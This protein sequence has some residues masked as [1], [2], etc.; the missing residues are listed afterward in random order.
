[1]I[2]SMWESSYNNLYH[3]ENERNVIDKYSIKF[4]FSKYHVTNY[5]DSYDKVTEM[6]K[7]TLYT[8]R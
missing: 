4:T 2:E 3:A 5:L 8:F 6:N 7:P 1:M